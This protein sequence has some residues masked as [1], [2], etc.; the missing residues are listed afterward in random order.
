VQGLDDSERVRWAGGLV[1]SNATLHIA[2]IMSALAHATQGTHVSPWAQ[3]QLRRMH[4]GECV[5]GARCCV[6]WKQVDRVSAVRGVGVS[7]ETAAGT[8][9]RERIASTVKRYRHAN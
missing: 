9:E 6:F 7:D 8:R 2:G 4:G 1:C 3:G 5:S